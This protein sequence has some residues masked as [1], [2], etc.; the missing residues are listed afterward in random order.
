MS[1]NTTL[2]L[3]DLEYYVVLGMTKEGKP[4]TLQSGRGTLQDMAAMLARAKL[5]LDVETMKAALEGY[6]KEKERKASAIVRP[7]N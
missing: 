4:V 2:N 7:S 5:A 6:R 1:D 3:E